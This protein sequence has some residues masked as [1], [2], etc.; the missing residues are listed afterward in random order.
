MTFETVYRTLSQVEAAMVRDFLMD[1][2]IACK[3]SSQFPGDVY[4][5]SV[6]EIQVQVNAEHA[7]QALELVEAYFSAETDLES[8]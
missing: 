8:S 3:L 4:G 7:S 6:E 2:G 1:Q 5:S